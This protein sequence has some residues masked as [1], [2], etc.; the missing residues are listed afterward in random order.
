MTFDLAREKTNRHAGAQGIRIILKKGLRKHVELGYVVMS[1][2]KK[3]G[4]R[5][6]REEPKP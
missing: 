1:Y 3:D 6:I 5:N 4:L 2:G